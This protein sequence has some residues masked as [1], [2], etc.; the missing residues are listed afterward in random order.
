[1]VNYE[2]ISLISPID[3]ES[4]HPAIAEFHLIRQ[5]INKDLMKIKLIII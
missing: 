4:L 3:V 1:M 2:K 5:F